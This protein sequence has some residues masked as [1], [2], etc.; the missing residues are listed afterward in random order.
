L[1]FDAVRIAT[2]HNS[3]PSRCTFGYCETLV[4]VGMPHTRV[5]WPALDWDGKLGWKPPTGPGVVPSVIAA[6]QLAAV[7]QD[8]L[9]FAV[10][11]NPH[12]WYSSGTGIE[13][14]VLDCHIKNI[15][16]LKV[17]L[18]LVIVDGR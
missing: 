8:L 16:A 18:A 13:F 1:N 9:H 4:Q 14:V 7:P 17:R 12:F 3:I 10:A 2:L 5:F 6:F 15:Y 11:E